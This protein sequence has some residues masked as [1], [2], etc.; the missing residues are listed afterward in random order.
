MSF[1][2][3]RHD[4]NFAIERPETK[5]FRVLWSFYFRTTRN[6]KRPR[7]RE[8]QERSWNDPQ[9]LG[10]EDRTVTKEGRTIQ[11]LQP[12]LFRSCR[13]DPVPHSR[14]VPNHSRT[15]WDFRT[16]PE[17]GRN[18][19]G[20]WAKVGVFPPKK[21]II[22]VA[23]HYRSDSFRNSQSISDLKMTKN[24][25]LLPSLVL[26]SFLGR[27]NSFQGHSVIPVFSNAPRTRTP[28][29]WVSFDHHLN[30]SSGPCQGLSQSLETYPASGG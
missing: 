1:Y 21:R 10:K 18:E 3:M 15:K 4:N 5:L 13:S 28:F 25:I 19:E 2:S 20:G 22:P 24:L 29:V 11:D 6:E 7:S 16:M 12:F 27:L 9:C 26:Q 17:Q 14:V 30:H 23:F 8:R